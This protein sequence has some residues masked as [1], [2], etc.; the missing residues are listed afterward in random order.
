MTTAP[1]PT[2]CVSCDIIAYGMR[3]WHKAQA[4]ALAEPQTW[5]LPFGVVNFSLRVSPRSPDERWH[6]AMAEKY[7]LCAAGNISCWSILRALR[8]CSLEEQDSARREC[9]RKGGFDT[10]Y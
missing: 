3:G 2:D 7:L 4:R 6:V 10:D 9:L 5:R 1:P 8:E